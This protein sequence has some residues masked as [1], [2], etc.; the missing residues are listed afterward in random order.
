[1]KKLTFI[2][3]SAVSLALFSACFREMISEAEL[4]VPAM[5]SPEAAKIVSDA[6]WQIGR[7][8]TGDNITAVEADW[9]N[10]VVRVRYN[11]AELKLRNLQVAV[12]HVGFAVDDLPADETVRSRLP[13]SMR[14]TAVPAADTPQTRTSWWTS[15]TKGTAVPA[16]D[17]P[18]TPENP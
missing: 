3:L 17:T 18:Q 2:L 14:G 9:T 7:S 15:T 10:H 1:M 12:R 4:Q 13:A 5:N 16:A 8:V 11:N 6:L